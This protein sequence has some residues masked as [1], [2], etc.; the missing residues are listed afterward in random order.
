MVDI[1][2]KALVGC[3]IDLKRQGFIPELDYQSFS[4]ACGS[5]PERVFRGGRD[6]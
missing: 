5:F 3:K 4:D 1:D 6:A 2:V